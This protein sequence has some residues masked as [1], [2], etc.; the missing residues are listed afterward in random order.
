[1]TTR[2]SPP[3]G[4]PGWADLWTCDVQGGGRS[5]EAHF[6]LRGNNG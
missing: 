4:V 2:T 3:N 5:D 6:R 1:M